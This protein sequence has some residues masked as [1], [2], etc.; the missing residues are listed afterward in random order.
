ML[1]RSLLEDGDVLVRLHMPGAQAPH[2]QA[3]LGHI[4]F[5]PTGIS[6]TAAS[7]FDVVP[8][9]HAEDELDAPGARRAC[10]NKPGRLRTLPGGQACA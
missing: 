1:F 2:V 3:T 10:I 6:L 9:G 5:Q 7:H 4:T 8:A